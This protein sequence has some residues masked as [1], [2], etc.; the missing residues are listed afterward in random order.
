VS[1]VSRDENA[2]HPYR[3]RQLVSDDDIALWWEKD[4]EHLNREILPNM[5]L[6]PGESLAE[7]TEYFNSA[8]Y[9][10]TIMNLHNSPGAGGSPL[11]FVFFEG[12]D[13]KYLGFASYKIYTQED[14]KAFILEFA[15][16]APLRNAGLGTK[17]YAALEQVLA[18]EGGTYVALN[19]SNQ[20]NLRF[21]KRQ[22]F[23]LSP[24]TQDGVVYV[25]PI[26]QAS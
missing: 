15:V 18:D 26:A 19:T 22:G 7:V 24:D 13:G 4:R 10:Q 6:E 9:Y 16:D 5:E 25:K 12:D 14:G 3:V 2:S 20:N 21:W 17:L 1:S 11:Q 8:D 23:T